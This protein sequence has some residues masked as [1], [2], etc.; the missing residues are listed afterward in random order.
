M[1]S[2]AVT[3]A[4]CEA[5][6]LFPKY[7]ETGITGA[8]L[9]AFSVCKLQLPQVCPWQ[10]LG[11]WVLIAQG[12]GTD[13]NETKLLGVT[14]GFLFPRR[15]KSFPRK[16]NCC[17][18]T[19]EGCPMSL[20]SFSHSKPDM[21]PCPWVKALALLKRGTHVGWSI[22][23]AVRKK[24]KNTLT[25]NH[26]LKRKKFYYLAILANMSKPARHYAVRNKSHMERK[27]VTWSHLNVDSK[28]IKFM[29]K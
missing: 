3:R 1:S 8:L 15:H 23:V 12:L 26:P 22:L 7:I 14:R 28:I 13:P 17:R 20:L 18:C 19:T 2:Y 5:T 29:E 6:G 27:K 9:R 16:G 24:K 10:P 4:Q 11:H 25:L 21:A